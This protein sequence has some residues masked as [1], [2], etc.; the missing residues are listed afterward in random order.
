MKNLY[1]ILVA[2][3]VFPLTA[4]NGKLSLSLSD[5]PAPDYQAVYVTISQIQVHSV[6]AE[7]GK[8]QTILTPNATYN[9]L[10]LVNGTTAPLGVASLPTGKYTQMR[11]ILGTTPDS[12][13][14]PYA[15]YLINSEGKAIE[16]KIPSGFQTG[17]KLVH[18]FDV[19]FGRTVGLVLDFDA[20]RSIVQAGKSGNWLLKPTIKVTGTV[21]NATVTGTVTDESQNAIPGATI[22]AQIYNALALSEAE[23]VIVV[24]S[25]ITDSEGKYLMYLG[26][27]TYNIVATANGYSTAVTQLITEYDTEYT[28]NFI[29][30]LAS[31]GL[32]NIDLTMPSD[33]SG[34]ASTI[35]FRQNSAYGLI[36]VKD[37]NYSE[38]GIYGVSLPIG[39][40]SVVG[41][42][43]D[44]VFLGNVTTGNTIGINFTEP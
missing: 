20:G 16:L 6:D 26:P 35:E 4:C 37:V 19:V 40:Y 33:S 5:A 43:I 14:H 11:L 30:A 7:D 28:E 13:S 10:E 38:S 21:N 23:K 39:S 34:E 3:F 44:K 12:E 18:N 36:A 8:W 17:I 1:L 29:L 24:A 27:G 22:S 31:M 15:N 41:T 42:Y 9:L 32:V 25:T 2:L